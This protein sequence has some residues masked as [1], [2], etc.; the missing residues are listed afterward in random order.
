MSAI[1]C[2]TAIVI[3]PAFLTGLLFYRYYIKDP[4]RS[5]PGPFLA[6]W[7]RLWLLR[8]VY[9]G[10]LH[11]SDIKAHEKYGPIYRAAPN[12]VIVNDPKYIHESHKWNRS[13]WFITLD[14][15]VGLQSVGTARTMSQHNFQR[16]R[17]APAYNL[18]STYK[19]EQRLDISILEFIQTLNIRFAMTGKVCDLSDYIHFFA[20]DTIMDLAFSDRV[21]FVKEGRDVNNII[22]S[23]TALFG[24]TRIMTTFPELQ[25]LIN[26]KWV[27]PFLGSKP[28]DDYGPGMVRGMAIKEVERR[29]EGNTTTVANDLLYRFMQYKDENGKSIPRRDLEVE[30]FTPVIAGP[31]S[32]ATILRVAIVYIICT[33]RVYRRLMAE[34]DEKCRSGSL[35]TPVTY[36][37]TKGLPFLCAVVKEVFRIHPP[38]GTPFPRTVPPPGATICGHFLPGGCDVGFSMWALGRNKTVFGDDVDAFRPERWM[39]SKEK[40]TSYEK[41]D[42]A[43]SAGLTTCLGKHIALFEIQKTLVEL[44]RNFEI[45]LANPFQPCMTNN[46]LTFV[47]H[48]MPVRINSRPK[49]NSHIT[50][51]TQKDD[52]A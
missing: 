47:V 23:L 2:V 18:D 19:M 50:M 48:N 13:D 9:S 42:L 43:F 49:A 33:P 4:L 32:V 39:D 52:T 10:Q 41:A 30:S 36:R 28:S 11:I 40:I 12:Y 31:E 3:A 46:I 5:V 8:Q 16:R 20:F 22:E 24:V 6:S 34:I 44:F 17:I 29:L 35:S 27:T 15:Q 25:K 7:S 14:P 26:H 45:N 37:E 21:G 38:I 51:S 1:I